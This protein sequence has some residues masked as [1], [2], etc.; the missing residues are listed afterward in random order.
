MEKVKKN[1]KKK[2]SRHRNFK[3]NYGKPKRKGSASSE[4]RVR[5]SV[6]SGEGISTPHPLSEDSILNRNVN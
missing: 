4:K 2:W 1:N 5:E 3:E 6:K